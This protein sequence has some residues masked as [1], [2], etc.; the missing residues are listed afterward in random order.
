MEK[1]KTAFLEPELTLL[2]IYPTTGAET[3]PSNDMGSGD[4]WGLPEL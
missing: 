3:T 2:E 1:N 4:D